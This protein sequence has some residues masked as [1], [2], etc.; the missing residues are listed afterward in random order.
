MAM[1]QKDLSV[2]Y[3]TKDVRG[4]FRTD[5]KKSSPEDSNTFSFKVTYKL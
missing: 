2:F 4:Y 1:I 3:I 5:L